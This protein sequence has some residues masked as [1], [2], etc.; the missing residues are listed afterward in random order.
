MTNEV[1][2]PYNSNKYYGPNRDPLYRRGDLVRYG[3]GS[4]ALMFIT[5]VHERPDR[6]ETQWQA[7]AHTARYYGVQCM[8]GIV[9]AYHE[10]VQKASEEDLKQWNS[11]ESWRKR[12]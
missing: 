2:T 10:T 8:G 7:A 6:P 4:T 3:Y 1:G 12:R 5:D 9:G 11:C